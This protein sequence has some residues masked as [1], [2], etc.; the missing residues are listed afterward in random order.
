MEPL[1]S[2]DR[3]WALVLTVASAAVVLVLAARVHHS[4]SPLWLDIQAQRVADGHLFGFPLVPEH[5]AR[6]LVSLGNTSVFA[7]L[8]GAVVLAAVLLRDR[9]GAVVALVAGPL[10]LAATE[11]VGK[12]LVGRRE[13]GGYGFPSGHTTAIATVV[14]LALLVAYRRGG[15]RG[16]LVVAPV[17]V[18]VPAMALALMRLNWHLFT[19]TVAGALVGGG[20][21]LGLAWL[22]SA[23]VSRRSPV[24]IPG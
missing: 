14:A 24:P 3:H 18:I 6:L 10:A 16:L 22:A 11:L 20:T 8:I 9:I 4:A 19:D 1:N 21:V 13:G 17:A 23:V 2:R 7:S 12:P 15:L 5:A